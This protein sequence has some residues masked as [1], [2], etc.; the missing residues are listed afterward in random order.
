MILVALIILL[1]KDV[2]IVSKKIK[3]VKKNRKSYSLSHDYILTHSLFWLIISRF[4][5]CTDKKLDKLYRKPKMLPIFQSTES[6]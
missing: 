4:E 1:L 2:F 5:G 6:V 3:N